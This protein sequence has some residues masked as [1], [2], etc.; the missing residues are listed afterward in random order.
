MAKS[1]P[2]HVSL[3]GS[4][5]R[6]LRDAEDLGPADPEE[7][8]T[9][10]IVLNPATDTRLPPQ[11]LSADVR[12]HQYL[13]RADLA[14]ERAAEGNLI[15]EIVHFARE[16]GL[17]AEPRAARRVV[18]VTGTVGHLSQA[19]QVKLRR[20]RRAGQEWRG[21][22]GPVSVPANLEHAVVAVLG[23][24][25]R[26]PLRPSLRPRAT[27]RPAGYLPEEVL[28]WYEF[29]SHLR[30]KRQCIA[31]AEFG[32]GFD[33]RNL[34][35]YYDSIGLKRSGI[36]VIPVGKGANRPGIHANFDQEVM[37]DVQLAQAIAPEAKIVLYF[38]RNGTMGVLD[39]VNAAIDDDVN[40]PS[41]LSISWGGAEED[42]TAQTV[43]AVEHALADAARIGLTVVA[44]SGD[45]GSRD[46]LDDGKVHVHYPASSPLVL[47]CGGTRITAK[48]GRVESEVAWNDLGEGSTGGGISTLFTD[49]PDFQAVLAPKRHADTKRLG[50]GVPDV[51]A[52]ASPLCGYRIGLAAGKTICL[53][54]TSAVAPIMAGLLALANEK[55]T[56][57]DG[58]RRS[59][60]FVTAALYGLTSQF[61]DITQGNNDVTGKLA[62]YKS[63]L[64]WDP[65]TGIG[66]PKAAGIINAL[67]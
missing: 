40:Q 46:N 1:P 17:Q 64:G 65:C 55:L 2:T 4:Y 52:H 10:T 28:T 59:V 29:P 67:R 39:A 47:G 66:T 5:R 36:S 27:R 58:K 6:H 38:C 18:E 23:L 20:M 51:S 50:R 25:D 56:K 60:G 11:L 43:R 32:G 53:G 62:G 24:D 3:K 33:Q 8:A 34:A 12:D 22:R 19:F 57:Q 9:V 31:I 14:A 63:G 45:D 41:V 48:G 7:S 44:S 42:W 61:N 26:A 21:R 35:K 49:V 13:S 37:L 15:R 30:G 54:G 16:S